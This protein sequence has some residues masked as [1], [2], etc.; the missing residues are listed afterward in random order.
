VAASTDVVVPKVSFERSQSG[1]WVPVV[2]YRPG[3]FAVFDR[4]PTRH[5]LW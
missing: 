2:T 5:R 4:A 1:L 3:D